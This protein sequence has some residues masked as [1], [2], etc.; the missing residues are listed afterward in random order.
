VAFH[1]GTS[2]WTYPDWKGSFYPDGLPARQELA[3]YA[4]R[5]GSVE[6]DSSFYAEPAP[7][8]LRHWAEVTPAHFRFALK[9]PRSITHER[10][11][12]DCAGELLAFLDHTA[13]LG[14]RRG[15]VILQ[16][17]PY[18]R[19][20]QLP[21][22]FVLLQELPPQSG[23]CVEFRDRSAFTAE[24]LQLLRERG[25]GLVTTDAHA[26]LLLSGPDVVLR[27]LG[28][29]RAVTRFDRVSVDR[30][31][32]L[33]AWTE[34]LLA[35]P[36]SVRDAWVFVNNHF[37]GHSPATAAELARRLGLPPPPPAPGRQGR[38]FG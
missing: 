32:D 27:L 17:P 15:P 13:V 31:E 2:G 22:L 20:A 36:S 6:V 30:G 26:G 23:L 18:F 21:A 38:L 35:L 33:A 37:S 24:C 8:T 19:A 5:L 16:L 9:V 3:Y 28:D 14:L 4:T 12:K 29:R 1:V 25:V 11:L 7:S 34:R 10:L